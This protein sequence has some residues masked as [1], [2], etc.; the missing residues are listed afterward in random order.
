MANGTEEGKTTVS[1]EQKALLDRLD[2]L[3]LD[4]ET[5][6][7]EM[8]LR[9]AQLQDLANKVQ[10]TQTPNKEEDLGEPPDPIED[11]KGYATYLAKVAR[12]GSVSKEEIANELKGYLT[13]AVG[14][15]DQL[16]QWRMQNPQLVSLEGDI[17]AIAAKLPGQDSILNKMNQAAKMFQERLKASGIE[18]NLETTKPEASSPRIPGGSQTSSRTE[19]PKSGQEKEKSAEEIVDE[20][21]KERYKWVD[22]RSRI[23]TSSPTVKTS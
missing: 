19:I 22:Q 3:A 1:P 11:P 4:N 16:W 20:V 17:G 21:I 18:L 13:Q 6:R 12:T 7:R 9:D 23:G 14:A 8:Q 5:L 10:T 2:K 15:L